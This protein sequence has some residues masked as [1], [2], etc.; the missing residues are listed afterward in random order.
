MQH[1]RFNNNFMKKVLNKISLENKR[2]LIVGDFNLNMIKYRHITIV[3]QFL[4]VKLTNN[5]L[6]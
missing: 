1:F 3:N 4:E 5:F 2:S 6:P